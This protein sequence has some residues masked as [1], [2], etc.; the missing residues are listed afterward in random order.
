MRGPL[1]PFQLPPQLPDVCF[2][3]DLPET[4][5][6]PLPF[7]GSNSG[8]FFNFGT[9]EIES[10]IGAL[11]ENDSGPALHQMVQMRFGSLQSHP[12]LALRGVAAQMLA[13][14]GLL[15]FGQRRQ[16]RMQA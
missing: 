11:A 8:Q 15:R 9:D 12:G 5:R 4:R 16:D 10:E 3:H 7:L 6:F 14:C 13:P 2:V 1:E